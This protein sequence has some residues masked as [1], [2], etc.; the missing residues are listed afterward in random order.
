M[1]KYKYVIPLVVL[2]GLSFL[3]GTLF[4]HYYYLVRNEQ[5][6]KATLLFS[7]AV[8]KEREIMKPKFMSFSE[9]KN[10][11]RS[12]SVTI[13]TAKGK[14]VYKQNYKDSLTQY[15]REAWILQMY[16][17][18]K[19]PNRAYM[20]DSLFQAELKEA[21]L[22]AHTAVCFLKGE[23][24]VGCSN[25]TVY[26]RGVGLDTIIFGEEHSPVCIELCA[27]VLFPF[28]YILS[29][30][31]FAW[32]LLLLWCSSVIL[33]YLWL[34]RWRKKDIMAINNEQKIEILSSGWEKL[35]HDLFFNPEMGELKNQKQSVFLKMY[36]LQAFN[37]LLQAPDHFLKYED[38]CREVLNRPLEEDESSEKN[39]QWN[40][41]VKKSM[42]QMITR[43]R[44]DLADFPEIS[45]ENVRNSGYQL[46][47]KSVLSESEMRSVS[48]GNCMKFPTG[49]GYELFPE[50]KVEQPYA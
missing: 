39:K 40:R 15:H 34:K 38:I 26:Q 49:L 33:I 37:R 36:R 4:F 18:D 43:L 41:S 17:S 6:L 19:N 29:C 28:S 47:I 48:G 27:Y 16:I 1:K 9:S 25:E 50:W 11:F 8:E 10:D 32:G 3:I 45:I 13:E 46:I 2:V 31:P 23:S 22:P 35:S 44:E 42:G 30:M 20:L 21:H 5:K 12:D 7:L 14:K 24:L